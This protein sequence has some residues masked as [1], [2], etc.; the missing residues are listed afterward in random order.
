MARHVFKVRRLPLPAPYIDIRD[1]KGGA[2][3]FRGG[4]VE[5]A[6]LLEARQIGAAVDDGILH[7]PYRVLSFEMVVFDSMG[8][9]VPLVSRG[10]AFTAEQKET[11]RN[12][13]RGRRLYISRLTVIGPDGIERKLNSSMEVIIR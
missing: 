10:S 8:N 11:I 13:G 12:L 3:I 1:E 6:R 4:T 7:I 9:A 5:R 2:D